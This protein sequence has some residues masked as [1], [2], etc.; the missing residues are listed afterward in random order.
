MRRILLSLLLSLWA[1]SASAQVNQP[2]TVVAAGNGVTVS[3]SGVTYTTNSKTYVLCQQSKVVA[4]ASNSGVT[5]GYTCAVPA[6]TLGT[7]GFIQVIVTGEFLNNTGGAANF[8]PQ[9]TF[10]GTTIAGSAILAGPASS[11]NPYGFVMRCYLSANNATNSQRSVC[12]GN[13]G[14]ATSGTSPGWTTPTMAAAQQDGIAVDSTGAQNI[15]FQLTW[16]ATNAALSFNLFSF[17]A[18][19]YQP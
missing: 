7:N 12:D 14:G 3:L 18:I 4:L 10:G 2:P 6:N 1:L 8:Q 15:V 9:I 5:T 11:A 17:V 13:L 16:G 19:L